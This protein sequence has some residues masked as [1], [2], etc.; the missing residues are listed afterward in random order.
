MARKDDLQDC[1]VR[2]PELVGRKV[3]VKLLPS[4]ERISNP[5]SETDV[6]LKSDFLSIEF[7]A[8]HKFVASV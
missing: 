5:N 8:E 4:P 6:L 3:E 2:L 7:Q 1:G